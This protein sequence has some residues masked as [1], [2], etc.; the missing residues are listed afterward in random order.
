[1]HIAQPHVARELGPL[2]NNFIPLIIELVKLLL[3][4]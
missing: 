2:Q 3:G 4:T 1:M